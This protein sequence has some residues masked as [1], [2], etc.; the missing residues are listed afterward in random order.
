MCPRA[1]KSILI[2]FSLV[3]LNSLQGFTVLVA[4]VT[5]IFANT[6]SK[7]SAIDSS[8][9]ITSLLILAN[10][11][12]INLIDRAGR[13]ILYVCSS[14]AT[15]LALILFAG[16][17]YFYAD[18]NAYD[19]MPIISVSLIIFLCGL[20]MG[21]VPFIVMIEIFPQNVRKNGATKSNSRLIIIFFECSQIQ[22]YGITGY[23]ALLWGIG[24]FI[25]EAYPPVKEYIGL[26]GWITFF[27]V[28]SLCNAL[29]GII[30]LP[31]TKG[32][33]HEAIMHLL[34]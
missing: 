11:I 9:I 10:L 25:C 16:Y 34:D 20:G 6:N 32:K 23:I 2:A 22:H 4:Y 19:W 27:A 30:V 21:P 8:I 12:V 3:C 17:L 7:W 18:D 31:E 15:S 29:F 28:I 5:E 26:F 1:R 24:F 14:L 13:R 33:S